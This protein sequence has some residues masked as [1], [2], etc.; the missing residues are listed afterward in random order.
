[1][2]LQFRFRLDEAAQKSGVAPEQ[3]LIF[4]T[5]TWIKPV[6]P[7]LQVFDEEDVARIQLIHELQESM[8]V[9]DDAVPVIMHLID[10]LNRLHLELSS[11]S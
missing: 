1:M 5:R 11:R 2:T 9:N 7:V 4:V 8:G 6:D 3:I 10:Q